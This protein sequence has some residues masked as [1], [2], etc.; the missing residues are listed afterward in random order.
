MNLDDQRPRGLSF[1]TARELC[2]YLDRNPERASYAALGL[3]YPQALQLDARQVDQRHRAVGNVH[4]LGGWC[5]EAAVRVGIDE[6]QL[7]EIVPTLWQDLLAQAFPSDAAVK[8]E[9][10]NS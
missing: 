7:A 5:Y 1:A 6:A 10:G 8:E 9:M 4:D 2:L 3:L